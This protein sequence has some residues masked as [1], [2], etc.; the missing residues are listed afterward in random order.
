MNDEYDLTADGHDPKFVRSAARSGYVPGP[1]NAANEEDR[2]WERTG[3]AYWATSGPTQ[4]PN[5]EF[6]EEYG[7]GFGGTEEQ[8]R[9]HDH[10]I[11]LLG[12]GLGENATK[13]DRVL[14]YRE[15]SHTESPI[16]TL[17]W[18]CGLKHVWSGSLETLPERDPCGAYLPSWFPALGFMHPWKDFKSLWV[19]IVYLIQS[20]RDY[21]FT[22]PGV[23]QQKPVE[24]KQYHPYDVKWKYLHDE[25]QGW[26]KCRNG[27]DATD[28]EL[29]CQICHVVEDIDDRRSQK[30]FFAAKKALVEWTYKCLKHMSYGRDTADAAEAVVLRQGIDSISRL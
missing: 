24:N 8:S 17:C 16:I 19:E 23:V 6:G 13:E 14:L 26:W 20:G 18:R 1:G 25:R 29:T 5:E 3:N 28:H 12:L 22:I 9:W 27:P 4:R 7:P 21:K 30:E 11:K 2:H 15:A 10:D